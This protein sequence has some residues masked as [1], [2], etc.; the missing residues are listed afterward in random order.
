MAISQ[1]ATG[2]RVC[3]PALTAVETAEGAAKNKYLLN[4]L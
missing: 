1:T 4:I 2:V 3:S